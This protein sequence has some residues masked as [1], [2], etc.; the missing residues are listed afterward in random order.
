METKLYKLNVSL[1]FNFILHGVRSKCRAELLGK[2]KP[3]YLP[4]H[5]LMA[6]REKFKIGHY[7]N[8]Q[9]NLQI[10]YFVYL[11]IHVYV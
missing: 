9:P 6:G 5:H 2:G 11:F 1:I 7:H 4:S 8:Y 10:Y 3:K